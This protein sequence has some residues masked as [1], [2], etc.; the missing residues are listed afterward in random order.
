MAERAKNFL[1][2]DCGHLTAIDNKC[3]R[4]PIQFE[5]ESESNTNVC[6]E[7]KQSEPQEVKRLYLAQNLKYLRS[8]TREKQRD[9]AELLGVSE[10][11][12]SRYE[13]GENEP[14]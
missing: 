9:I 8:K 1:V 13:S 11:T 6:S 10:M 3:V 4:N 7:L 2:E 5:S 12:V 14:E